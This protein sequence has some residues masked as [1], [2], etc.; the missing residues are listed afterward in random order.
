MKQ[1]LQSTFHATCLQC[2]VRPLA[3]CAHLQCRLV[4][5]DACLHRVLEE[6]CGPPV[7]PL[8][9]ADGPQADARALALLGTPKPFPSSSSGK[10]G[11]CVPPVTCV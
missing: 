8:V 10:L 7:F 9:G 6:G 1:D 11:W 3:P 2:R 5:Q 4:P